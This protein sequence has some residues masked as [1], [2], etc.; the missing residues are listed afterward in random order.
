VRTH[1][2]LA[3]CLAIGALAAPAAAQI[4]PVW[5]TVIEAPDGTRLAV[6]SATLSRTSDSTYLVR[7]ATTFP[8]P[9]A[10]D[11]GQA[12]REVDMEEFDCAHGRSRG[13]DAWLYL[14]ETRVLMRPLGEV[15]TSVPVAR[16]PVVDAVCSYAT[17]A[18]LTTLARA[19]EEGE[20]TQ[21][22]RLINI[23]AV[24]RALGNY[25]PDIL[26]D[27]G[28]SGTVTIRYVVAEDGRV[29]RGSARIVSS[30]HT[31]FETAALRVLEVMHF[32]PAKYRGHPV[33]IWVVQPVTFW[34][35]VT[36]PTERP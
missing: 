30:T 18:H 25:Y 12:D 33:R 29:D 8:E 17:A 7:T 31:E 22:P 14:G 2:L 5:H 1:S 26:R 20:V 24:Q 6:D 10:L 32:A 19:Y 23:D 13:F 28:I 11:S 35:P 9:I 15:W 16:R 4:T 34:V 21:M 3:T 36:T 27:A